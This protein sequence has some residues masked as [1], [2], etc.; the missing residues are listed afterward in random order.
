VDPLDNILKPVSFMHADKDALRALPN[1][2]D[3]LAAYSALAFFEDLSS[4]PPAVSALGAV[5][6][7]AQ[8]NLLGDGRKYRALS[9]VRCA[10]MCAK[11]GHWRLA[12]KATQLALCLAP[13]RATR[14]LIGLDGLS[15]Y[16]MT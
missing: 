6:R 11:M 3:L 12:K 10:R 2:V 4:T 7:C 14:W 15:S 13:G 9:L 1:A 5:I 8:Q 16:Q